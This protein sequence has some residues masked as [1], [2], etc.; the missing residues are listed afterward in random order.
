MDFTIG[1]HK[2]HEEAHPYYQNEDLNVADGFSK[3]LQKEFGGFLKAIVLFGSVAKRNVQSKGDIDILLIVDD[4]ST[5]LT[6][7]VSEA[8]RVI[9]E[10]HVR[11]TSPRLHITTLRLTTFWDYVKS[12]DPI[13]L[14]MLRSGA[15]LYDVGIFGPM[16]ELLKKGRIKPTEEAMWVYYARAPRTLQNAKWHI[17]HGTVDLYWAVI[18]A[19]HA[20]IIKSGNMPPQPE[21][22]ASVLEEKFVATKKLHKRYPKTM[23][24]L[25]IIAKQIMHG[26]KKGMTGEEF[27]ALY[28]EA[29]DF[30]TQIKLLLQDDA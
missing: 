2:I 16:Q 13:V 20:A 26:E 25:Y 12:G 23:H 24:K 29:G 14:N 5:V 9:V 28:K 11:Q 17:L 4:V 3:K 30:V 21:M 1:Q 22:V 19:A 10:G 7:E 27:D 6:T 8:Y 18:D 15:A